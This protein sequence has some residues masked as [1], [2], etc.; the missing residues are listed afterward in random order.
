MRYGREPDELGRPVVSALLR[1]SSETKPQRAGRRCF[2]APDGR[3]M[4]RDG[5]SFIMTMT[6][7]RDGRV[8]SRSIQSYGAATTQLSSPHYADKAPQFV[9]QQLKPAWFEPASLRGEIERVNCPPDGLAFA[10]T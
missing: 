4:V 7:G 10:P 3:L 9:C 2:A 1:A 8:S 6:W 5:D